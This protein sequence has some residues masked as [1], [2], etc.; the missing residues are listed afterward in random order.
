MVAV[1][2]LL[3]IL[4]AGAL[5]ASDLAA[6]PVNET[7]CQIS[8]LT[9]GSSYD[10]IVETLGDPDEEIPISVTNAPETMSKQLKYHGLSIATVS[11]LVTAMLS[12]G[13]EHSLA[14]GI[15]P[16]SSRKDVLETL[17]KTKIQYGDVREVFIYR[18]DG[19]KHRLGDTLLMITMTEGV[20]E[21]VAIA[22]RIEP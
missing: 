11:S 22:L 12:S 4:F 21:A 3:I 6:A 2:L 19:A 9:V 16:G 20:V 7:E 5:D 10:E 17:G 1:E 15:G 18:C 8:G 13:L 14:S